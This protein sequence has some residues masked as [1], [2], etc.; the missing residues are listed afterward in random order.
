MQYS[1]RPTHPKTKIVVGLAPGIALGAMTAPP[2]RG[3]EYHTLPFIDYPES[4]LLA[5]AGRGS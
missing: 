1:N 5:R 3:G 2:H 4:W